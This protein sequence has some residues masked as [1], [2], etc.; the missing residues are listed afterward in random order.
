MK[1]IC[2]IAGEPSGDL[3]AAEVIKHIFSENSEVDIFGIG[4]DNIL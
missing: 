2:M 1:S 4:G 3:Y